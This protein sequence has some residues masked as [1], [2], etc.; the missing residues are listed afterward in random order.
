MIGLNASLGC[1]PDTLSCIGWYE[2]GKCNS[3]GLLLLQLCEEFDLVIVNIRKISTSKRQLGNTHVWVTG[4]VSIIS[5]YN[6][7]IDV[8][9]NLM[10]GAECWDG[11]LV[12]MCRYVSLHS[13]KDKTWVCESSKTSR[14]IPL[15]L[16]AQ[17]SWKFS[18]KQLKLSTLFNQMILACFSWKLYKALLVEFRIC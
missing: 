8:M 15:C 13:P 12:T 9:C 10:R 18:W 2:I 17:R 4:T 3:N 11:S 5:L 16:P 7:E 1:D 14:F 6:I